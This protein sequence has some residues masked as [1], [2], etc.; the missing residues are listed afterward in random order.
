MKKATGKV[1]IYFD[2][3]LDQI[4]NLEDK[5][6]LVSGISKVEVYPSHLLNVAFEVDEHAAHLSGDFSTVRCVSTAG[7]R[8]VEEALSTKTAIIHSC[9]DFS[10]PTSCY[11]CHLLFHLKG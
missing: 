10:S 3:R 9:S 5:T 4:S 7:L 2:D 6:L 11:A 8:E 1:S